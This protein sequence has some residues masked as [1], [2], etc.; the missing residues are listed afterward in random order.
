MDA[1][2]RNRIEHF[3]VPEPNT[4]CWLWMGALNNGYGSVS[5]GRDGKKLLAHRASYAEY[6]GDPVG[7]VVM[8]KC[9]TPACVN[10]G[11][12]ALG[13]QLDNMLD[14][15][16]KRRSGFSNVSKEQRQ[17][18]QR[19]L[20]LSGLRGR[21]GFTLSERLDMLTVTEP[22]TGCHL[23]VGAISYGGYGKIKMSGRGRLAHRV[24]YAHKFGP[25][26]DGLMVLHKCDTP[27]CVNPDHLFL[28]D[29]KDN[30]VDAVKKGRHGTTR[31]SAEQ[32]SEWS[33]KRLAQE[34]IP[35]SDAMKKG[36]ETRHANG[37]AFTLTPEQASDRSKKAWVARKE[38]YG[39][40]G[41][42][43]LRT[44]E[45]RGE[46]ARNGWANA[47]PE[48]RAERAQILAESR[49]RKLAT[50]EARAEFGRKVSE[51][52]R[53]AREAREA[54]LASQ[55]PRLLFNLLEPRVEVSP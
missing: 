33:R 18:W 2:L 16:R 1:D 27:A 52:H 40:E 22:N 50:P 4:G 26:P 5:A 32:R 25:I 47:T 54:R 38:R 35:R 46:A 8:H 36:W 14:A 53:R 19:R 28:G 6:V 49:R 15:A 45:E 43:R 12:L 10:P 42:K 17:E 55:R 51:G 20:S 23:W 48:A 34:M 30:I 41:G 31:A 44:H 13:T 9:D 21:P 24:S 29:A 37:L 7:K 3:S 39:H 11:H